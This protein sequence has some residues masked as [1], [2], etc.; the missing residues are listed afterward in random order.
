MVIRAA[1]DESDAAPAEAAFRKFLR[2]ILQRGAK[3]TS[4]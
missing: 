3:L 4:F 1:S 2:V